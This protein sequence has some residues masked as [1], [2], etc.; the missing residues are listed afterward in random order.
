MLGNSHKPPFTSP[1]GRRR[2]RQ[3]TPRRT[4]NAMKRRRR[5]GV[6]GAGQGTRPRASR[7]GQNNRGARGTRRIW[8]WRGRQTSAPNSIRAWFSCDGWMP[9]TETRARAS[10]QSLVLT[11]LPRGLPATPKRRLRTRMT[12]PSRMGAGWLKAMLANGAGGVTA[13]AGQGQEVLESLRE[14]GRRGR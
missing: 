14:N 10:S 9:R 11:D 1:C 3:R 12:L 7:A 8:G 4:T 5:T 6:R 13:H 2:T